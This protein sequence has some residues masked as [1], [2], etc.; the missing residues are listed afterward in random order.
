[1]V[2]ISNGIFLHLCSGASLCWFLFSRAELKELVHLHGNECLLDAAGH[3]Q[4]HLSTRTDH[5]THDEITII[6]G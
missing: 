6:K 2:R 3:M 4:N 1:V 5:L